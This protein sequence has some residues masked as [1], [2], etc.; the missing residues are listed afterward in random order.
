MSYPPRYYPF[1]GCRVVA[2]FPS[3][4]SDY[5]DEPLNIQDLLVS[6]PASTFFMNYTARPIPS[7]MVNT[8]DVLVVDKSVRPWN[9][10]LVVL[11]Q[12]GD[13]KLRRWN[14]DERTEIESDDWYVWGV[15]VGLARKLVK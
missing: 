3:P 8:G 2:G 15:V 4:A 1:I 14:G 11:C 7:E 6:H 13:M 9:G 10:S 5:L 12:E